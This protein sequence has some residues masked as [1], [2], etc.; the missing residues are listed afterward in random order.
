MDTEGNTAFM[1]ATSQNHTEIA[2]ILTEAEEV[3]YNVIQ[4]QENNQYNYMLEDNQEIKI[5]ETAHLQNEF[6]ER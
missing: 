5:I 2:K 4:T 1:L 6:V 3:I